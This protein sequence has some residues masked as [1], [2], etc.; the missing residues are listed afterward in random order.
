MTGINWF[1][2]IG[3]GVLIGA[4]FIFLNVANSNFAIGYFPS[5]I[6]PADLNI[7][8]KTFI[9]SFLA[10]LVEE[11][12]FRLVWFSILGLLGVP[13]LWNLIIN[14]LSFS[15][16]HWWAYGG[17]AGSGFIQNLSALSG[18]FFGAVLFSVVIGGVIYWVNG[19]RFPTWIFIPAIIGHA[20]FNTYLYIKDLGLLSFATGG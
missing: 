12:A 5:A 19:K 6:F 8:G 15:A 14:A 20:L 10:P 13:L 3:F 17:T 4:F 9:V 16:Y 2:D 7:V 11:I 18:A 1:R